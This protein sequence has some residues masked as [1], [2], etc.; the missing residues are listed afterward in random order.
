MQRRLR[1]G[2]VVIEVSLAVVLLV[3]AAL[4]VRSF[5]KLNAID[6]GYNP[7]KLVALTIGLDSTRY[8]SE[9][10]RIAFLRQVVKDVEELPGVSGVAAASG[11]PP[12]PGTLG[13]ATMAFDAGACGQEHTPITANLVTPPYFGL[14]G[15]A[16]VEG[17]T[18]RADDPPDAVVVSRA[19]ARLCGADSLV[20]K[21][22]RLDT[23]AP[24]VQ[25]V[26]V[27]ADVKTRGLLSD[28]GDVAIYMSFAADPAVLPMTAMMME[29]RVVARRLIV[30]AE[31][32]TTIVGEVK[33]VLWAHDRDQPVLHAA[34][35]SELMGESIR[36]E[37]FMLALMTL[38]SAVAL[39]LASAGIFGVLAYAV[40]QRTNEIGIRMALG[41]SAA[42][43][44]KLVVG[45]GIAVA[46]LG[47]CGGLAGAFGL[48]R[49]L[50]G[51]LYEIDPRDPVVFIVAPLLV[52][53]VALLASWIP[54][55][56]ALKVDPASAL[57]VE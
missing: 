13:L 42:E 7:E 43:I 26:G 1:A 11:L 37:R 4:M 39:S 54:T 48:S 20:G 2:L 5:M 41:A 25:V 33:R 18:L 16:I 56:R 31:R 21:R 22:L 55:T 35:V 9:S 24:S 49:L 50:A 34:P 23:S 15:I 30:Q 12:S 10:A 19:L 44:R 6:I 29:R 8:V 28:D 36:R 47:I 52:L 27:A 46:A 17:R 51:L 32:P 14:M 38:F 40:A 45:H 3:G 57:R 53:I